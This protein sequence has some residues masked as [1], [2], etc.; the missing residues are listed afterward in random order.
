MYLEV[1]LLREKLLTMGA[2]E[3]GH[4]HMDHLGMLIEVSLLREF[5]V[6]VAA[7]KGALPCVR[8]QMVKILAHR[9]DTELASFVL[10]NGMLA[11]E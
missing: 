8:P 1:E 9:K 10:R 3:F 11:L 7:L 4:S 2:L 5:H 6:A